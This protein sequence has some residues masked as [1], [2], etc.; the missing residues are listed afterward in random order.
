MTA[1][2]GSTCRV[3]VDGGGEIEAEKVNVSNVGDRTTLSLR[4][5]RVEIDPPESMDDIVDGKI[6]E[7]I[8]LGDHIRVRM[9][10]AHNDEFIVKVRNS[11]SRTDLQEGQVVRIGWNSS[12]CKALDLDG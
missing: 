1:L 12:D 11:S 4:P 3:Q 6:E 5:E 7:L 2:N 10:V 8:Y 9:K